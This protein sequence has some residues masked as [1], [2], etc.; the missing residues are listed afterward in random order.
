MEMRTKDSDVASYIAQ[1]RGSAPEDLLARISRV[2][3]M[4][5]IDSSNKISQVISRVCI[6]T[7]IANLHLVPIST[8][9][10][11]GIRRIMLL[12]ACA[13]FEDHPVLSRALD[14][15]QCYGFLRPLHLVRNSNLKLPKPTML[16]PRASVKLQQ[17][18]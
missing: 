7:V 5:S 17:D 3:S 4:A 2:S 1:E 12:T 11:T 8:V 6:T 9:S 14:S 15:S 10:A 16:M 13:D 18:S